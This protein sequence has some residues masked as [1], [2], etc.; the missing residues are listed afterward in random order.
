LAREQSS[1]VSLDLDSGRTGRAMMEIEMASARTYRFGLPSPRGNPGSRP[2][3]LAA[4]APPIVFVIDDDTSVRRGLERLLRSVGLEVESFASSQEFIVRPLPDRP[5]C[6]VLDLRLPG[7]SGLEVQETLSRARRE[8]PI[9]FISGYADVASSVRALKAGAVDFLQKPFSNQAL[10]DI[11]HEALGRSRTSLRLRA[12]LA[13]IRERFDG[14][15]PR[16]RDVLRLVLKG[17]LNKQV[18]A[19]LGISEKTVKFHRGRV[20]EKTQ[21]GSVAELVR[22]AE[23]IQL[24]S[25]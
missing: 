6:V 14:L 17:L 24:G 7:A 11:V 8:I 16:E 18:A 1:T 23:K 20:M 12:E 2:A 13:S 25:T 21:A 19:E 4:D 3:E 5:A 22:L 9:I 10:L 15:T